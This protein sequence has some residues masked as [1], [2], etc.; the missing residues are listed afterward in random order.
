M[1]VSTIG[2]DLAK[3]VFQVH[4]VDV[5]G[6]VV[7][8]RQLRRNQVIEFL[9]KL[10]PCLVGMEACATAH[11]WAREIG[12]LGHEVRLIPPSYVKAY[13]R[14]QKNDAADAAAICEA[15]TRPS[16]RFV[17]IKSVEQQAILAVHRARALLIG[18]RTQ[19]T[20][21][22]RAH[23]AELG[24]VAD[25][26]REGLAKLMA[27]VKEEE[28]LQSLPVAMLQVVRALIAQLMS[29]QQQLGE[30]DRAI[31]E[32]HRADPVSRR[33]ETI[34]GIGII[35][36]TAIA[37]T[38]TDPKAFRSGRDLAAWIGL[39]PRQNSTGGKE[40]LGGISKQG[41]RYL[42]RLLVAGAMAVI[43]HARRHPQKQPWV[44]KLLARKPAKVVA[45]AIANKS[46]R[47]AWA[48][49]SHG[50]TYRPPAIAAAA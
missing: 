7:L 39:V 5:S 13:V 4:G 42:R 31:K 47:I 15:V 45:I 17:P 30:L 36:A 34:P 40:R 44:T 27:L 43:Q 18:Q 23:L 25:E 41:D 12:K 1:Q 3:N 19:I 38:V 22:L 33:L 26:G 2:I 11:H 48:I 50:G 21:A 37:A 9:A 29:V 32:Q 10:P 46:A 8:T 35:G 14:R 16:M 28:T 6:K 24:L 49:M 20:N